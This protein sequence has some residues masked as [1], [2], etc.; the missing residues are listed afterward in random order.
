VIALVTQKLTINAFWFSILISRHSELNKLAWSYIVSFCS[1]HQL[2]FKDLLLLIVSIDWMNL[3]FSKT[4][5]D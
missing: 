3:M 2:I 1:Q 5:V 4:L